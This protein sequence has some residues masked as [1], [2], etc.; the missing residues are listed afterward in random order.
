MNSRRFFN[1]LKVVILLWVG[2]VNDLAARSYSIQFLTTERPV[3]DGGNWLNGKTDGLDWADVAVTNSRAIGLQ[4]G[5]NPNYDDSTAVV[6][7]DW[8]PNQTASA[9]VRITTNR[10]PDGNFPELEIRLLTSISAHQLSGYEIIFSVNGGYTQLVR[11]NGPL[12]NFTYIVSTNGV[13]LRDGDV[14]KGTVTNNVFTG[15]VNNVQV[16]QGTDSTFTSGNPGIG[17]FIQGATGLNNRFGFSSFSATDGET[18]AGSGQLL[19]TAPPTVN[20]YTLVQSNGVPRGMYRIE[21]TD[22]LDPA[23]WQTLSTV[24][25]N[26]FGM[27]E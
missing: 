21:Y 12:N 2:G 18:P 14:I 24:T 9:T 15:Y 8:G 17:M 6:K 19:I 27:S 4:S 22:Q 16:I 20:T 7:G 5:I 25:A 26:N 3:S 13:F 11:W 10:P 1:V 23:N